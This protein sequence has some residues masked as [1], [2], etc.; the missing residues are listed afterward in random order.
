MNNLAYITDNKRFLAHAFDLLLYGKWCKE[1]A[2]DKETTNI[3]IKSNKDILFSELDE[4]LKE[5]KFDD[6]D[7]YDAKPVAQLAVD[8]MK[9]F[10][11]LIEENMKKPNIKASPKGYLGL[12]WITNHYHILLTIDEN[13][14]LSYCIREQNKP[15]TYYDGTFRGYFPQ[16]IKDLISND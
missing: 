14:A 9:I 13:N 10:I 5:T 8:K 6:W 3:V 7:G 1:I 12:S 11:N 4:V 15:T 2:F 16:D